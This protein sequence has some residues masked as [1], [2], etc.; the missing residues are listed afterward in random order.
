MILAA[1][2]V[3]AIGALALA[4]SLP[5]TAAPVCRTSSPAS[6]A[7]TVTV[8]MT[9]PESGTT[10][11]GDTTV[12]ATVAVSN[13]KAIR[14]VQFGVAGGHVLTDFE[15]P[16]TLVLP[17][18]RWSNGTRSLRVRAVVKGKP[19]F[20]TPYTFSPVT[21]A[22]DGPP[23][24]S[25]PFAAH[26]PAVTQGAPLVVAA[27]GDGANGN[28]K[29]RAVIS[30]IA[31][32]NP[33]LFLYLGD[34]YAR[35]THT[36]FHNWFAPTAQ[37]Y[38]RFA[39][40]TNPTVGNHEYEGVPTA[41]PYFSYWGGVPHAYSFDA[42]GWH[43]VSLDTTPDFGQTTPGS[44]QFEW[45]RA[46]LRASGADCTLVYYHHPVFSRGEG[47]EDPRLLELWSLLA[48]EGVD[49][50]LN[51]HAHHYTR[52]KPIGADRAANA[53]G[54]VQ[55]TVGSGGHFLY[56]F[57]RPDDRAAA[58]NA[59][60]FGALRLELK[61]GAASY[62]F[63]ASGGASIDGSSSTCT[64]FVD[65]EPPTAPVLSAEESDE[66]SVA[67]AWTASTDDVAVTGYRILR[68]GVEIATVGP[69]VTDHLDEGLAPG[70]TYAYVV[71]AFDATGAATASDVVTVTLPLPLPSPTE[72]PSPTN[73]P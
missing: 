35:G 10:I 34:V 73:D 28:A 61:P 55:I 44:E 52:W 72:E 47:N 9:V 42:G 38:G 65:R 7:Y 23:P 20:I 57:S 59:T 56:P 25:T 1:V 69:E 30:R 26:E 3:A 58:A 6:G 33:Q 36:E 45:L 37:T 41:E 11:T 18:A 48:E 50:V 31:S 64:P 63:I 46:D 51:G 53:D 29:S 40:I 66:T 5:A 21:F 22:N 67:L 54:P 17:S 39:P 43:F 15:S 19:D 62:R 24:A 49:L 4:T 12:T 70:A 71:E 27:V 8:C 14:N 16:Y 68:D 13:G 32:W 60:K 2:A